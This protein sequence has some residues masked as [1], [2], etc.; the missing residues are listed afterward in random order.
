M[1]RGTA[2]RPNVSL[3][4]TSHLFSKMGVRSSDQQNPPPP[5]KTGIKPEASM[6]Q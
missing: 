3:N 6:K 4:E 2:M 1:A 5:K